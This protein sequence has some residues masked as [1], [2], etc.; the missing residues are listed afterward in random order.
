MN[1]APASPWPYVLGAIVA[2]VVLLEGAPQVGGLVLGVLVAATLAHYA[3]PK[4]GAAPSVGG[5]GAT[6]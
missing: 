6:W 1:N 4:Q 3:I 5:G 2:V